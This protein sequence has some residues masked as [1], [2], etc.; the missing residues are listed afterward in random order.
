VNAGRL[1]GRRA[2]RGGDLDWLTL[3]QAASYLGVAQSTLR[4]WTDSG[5]VPAFKTPGGHR[6]YRRRDLDS[7]LERSGQ[8]VEPGGPLVLIVD[9]DDGVRAFVRA[10]LELEGYTVRE[11]ASAEE[12]LALLEEQLPDLILLDVMMPQVDGWEMLRLLHER[13]GVG[14]IPVIMFSGQVDEGTLAAAT[15]RGASGVLGK[16]FDPQELIESAKRTL[17]LP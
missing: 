6:R 13:H 9:D 17:P 8:T 7:F 4:K 1:P 2:D 16:G 15:E 14:S 10:N 3:G 12:G 11:A 5:R